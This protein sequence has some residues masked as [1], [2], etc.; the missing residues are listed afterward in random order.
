MTTVNLH[1][2]L[3]GT[4]ERLAVKLDGTFD[5]RPQHV[6]EDPEGH[7]RVCQSFENYF[8][9]KWNVVA[10]LLSHGRPT[11]CTS[12]D[13]TLTGDRNTS[14]SATACITMLITVLSRITRC[15]E[16]PVGRPTNQASRSDISAVLSENPSRGTPMRS[17]IVTKRFDNGISL[18]YRR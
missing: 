1:H 7:G 15:A 8:R 9:R 5:G 2:Q 16:T 14:S 17:S 11:V 4:D 6:T 3:L 13:G 12:R 10:N 18:P